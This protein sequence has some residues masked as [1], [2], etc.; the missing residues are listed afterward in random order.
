MVC[1][2]STIVLLGRDL[3]SLMTLLFLLSGCFGCFFCFVLVLCLVGV[4]G[5]LFLL[6]A[7]LWYLEAGLVPGP[8][9]ACWYCLGPLVALGKLSWLPCFGVASATT[10]LV[11]G[12]GLNLGLGVNS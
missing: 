3:F 12:D 11:A 6:V 1:L 9:L 2:L 10:N 4:R 8:M 5:F 7:R